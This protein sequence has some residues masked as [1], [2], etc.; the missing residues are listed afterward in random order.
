MAIVMCLTVSAAM[1]GEFC[2]CSKVRSDL[3]AAKKKENSGLM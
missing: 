2:G 3:P 1:L